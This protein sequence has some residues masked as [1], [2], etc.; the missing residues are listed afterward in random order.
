MKS[1]RR[2][3]AEKC[4]GMVLKCKERSVAFVGCRRTFCLIL[5]FFARSG[6]MRLRAHRGFAADIEA[7]IDGGLLVDLWGD[8]Y[9]RKDVRRGGNL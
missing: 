7:L 1:P 5:R 4:N 2:E 8:L 6:V 3:S 9:L